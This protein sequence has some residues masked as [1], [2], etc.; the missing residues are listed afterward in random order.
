M[1]LLGCGEKSAVRG[2][3]DEAQQPGIQMADEFNVRPCFD[4]AGAPCAPQISAGSQ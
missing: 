4:K 3:S 2:C 1:I